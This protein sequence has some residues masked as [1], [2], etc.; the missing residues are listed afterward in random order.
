MTALA[1]LDC[2]GEEWQHI[3]A[4]AYNAGLMAAASQGA[5]IDGLWKQARDFAPRFAGVHRDVESDEPGQDWGALAQVFARQ[6]G[7]E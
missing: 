7:A 2:W 6:F 3:A 1:L 4:S 5:K